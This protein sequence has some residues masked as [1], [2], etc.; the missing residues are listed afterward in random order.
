MDTA[1]P[2]G[3][4]ISP[5]RLA[6]ILELR[7]RRLGFSEEELAECAAVHPAYL[8]TLLSAE[9]G[10][11]RDPRL[12]SV[13]SALELPPDL[14]EVRREGRG[15]IDFS[16]NP[17]TRLDQDVWNEIR[18]EYYSHQRRLEVD[19][20]EI[21]FGT[22]VISQTLSPFSFH[23]RL[24]PQVSR[25]AQMLSWKYSERCENVQNGLLSGRVCARVLF[26]LTPTLRFLCDFSEH[27][28]LLYFSHL[29]RLWSP[30]Y[31]SLRVLDTL[32]PATDLQHFSMA[33]VHRNAQSGI[34]SAD[35]LVETARSR[36]TRV[37]LVG[38]TL[39]GNT[40]YAQRL[41]LFLAY[42]HAP[43]AREVAPDELQALATGRAA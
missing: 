1:T 17:Q 7:Q 32:M 21:W 12:I 9:P 5:S 28:R 35:Q 33:I 14:V 20:Q 30:G 19:A 40:Y 2:I 38:D 31:L 34:A 8:Q 15:M 36:S 6:E 39:E 27:E 42:W 41:E 24:I 29:R 37:T 4:A 25:N 23:E 10:A 3:D 16:L 11:S 43:T 22:P 13:L 26:L 18:L